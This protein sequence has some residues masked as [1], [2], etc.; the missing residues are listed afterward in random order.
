[1]PEHDRRIGAEVMAQLC[2]G[3]MRA[4]EA[5]TQ[6]AE[7]GLRVDNSS[8]VAAGTAST[9][10]ER[11]LHLSPAGGRAHLLLR[12]GDLLY[13][14][15]PV[16]DRR[17][18]HYGTAWAATPHWGSAIRS[19]SPRG[20]QPPTGAAWAVRRRVGIG[21]GGPLRR[22]HDAVGVAE[23]REAQVVVDRVLAS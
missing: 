7:R 4:A 23:H 9:A 15:M 21:P 20:R 12:R 6:L 10:G 14:L 8:I 19:G 22:R 11:Q 17:W 18:R 3:Q 1:V 16:N 13:A 5:E 2:D